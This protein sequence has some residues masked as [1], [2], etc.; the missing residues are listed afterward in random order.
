MVNA[1]VL[2]KFAALE[3]LETLDVFNVHEELLSVFVATADNKLT[4][5][6]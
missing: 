5:S 2:D 1:V 4:T 6:V 3:A